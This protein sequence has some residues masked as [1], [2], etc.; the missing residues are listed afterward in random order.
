VDFERNET[1][2]G[3][4]G[5]DLAAFWR[6]I[7]WGRE[8]G[9]SVVAKLSQRF[10]GTSDRWLQD[11]ARQLLASGLALSGQRCSGRETFALR[12]ESVLLAVDQWHTPAILAELAP[13]HRPAPEIADNDLMQLVRREL[14]GLFWPWSLI[15]EDRYERRA[16]LL[17]HCANSRADYHRLATQHGV[18]LDPTFHVDGWQNDSSY[19]R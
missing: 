2:I 14:G 9:L 12:T 11:G 19:L 8:R 7:R 16:G 1:R 10:I 15:G 18:E 3:H 17:W 4:T 13:R 6:G 5:G